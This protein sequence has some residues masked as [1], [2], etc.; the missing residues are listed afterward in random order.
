[1]RKLCNILWIDVIRH[2]LAQVAITK[3]HRLTSNRNVFLIGL[4]AGS[5]RPEASVIGFW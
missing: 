5:L 2:V 3:Y 1:M 4:E